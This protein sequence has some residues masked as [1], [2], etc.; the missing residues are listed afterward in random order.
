MHS[1][2]SRLINPELG[3][4]QRLAQICPRQVL[5]DFRSWYMAK[6]YFSGEKG[7]RTALILKPNG[8]LAEV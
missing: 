5:A 7:H 2:D 1:Y 3:R 4:H 6:D 8:A